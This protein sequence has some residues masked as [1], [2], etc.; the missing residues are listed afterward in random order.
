MEDSSVDVSSLDRKE[1]LAKLDLKPAS[2]LDT[3]RLKIMLKNSLQKN[4]PIHDYLRHLSQ[5]ILRKL[6]LKKKCDVIYL[7]SYL[8][9]YLDHHKLKFSS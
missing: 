5:D 2:K 3:G 4:H 1:I 6:H 7:I 9:Q 8:E